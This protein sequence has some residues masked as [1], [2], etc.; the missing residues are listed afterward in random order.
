MRNEQPAAPFANEQ[1][2]ESEEQEAQ[3]E[4]ERLTEREHQ[5]GKSRTD[6]QRVPRYVPLPLYEELRGGEEGESTEDRHCLAP[7]D[8]DSGPE[9]IFGDG[10]VLHDAEQHRPDGEEPRADPPEAATSPAPHPPRD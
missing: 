1:R 2:S 9:R 7:A 10:P 5:D 8:A 3:R 6:Q 4:R